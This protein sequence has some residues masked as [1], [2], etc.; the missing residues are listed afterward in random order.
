MALHYCKR[1]GRVVERNEH[2]RAED[3]NYKCDSCHYNV[4]PVPEKYWLDGLDYL[5]TKEQKALLREELVK[6]SPEYDEAMFK[7]REIN[8]A[9]ENARWAEEERLR[10]MQ[11]GRNMVSCTYCGST[12]ISKIGFLERL[13]SAELWGL[14][15]SKIGKQFHCNN[16]GANF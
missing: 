3:G 16:C 4:Y 2:N 13:G 12:N 15:S 14:G 10:T 7:R 5:I 8:L 11:A 9:A 1:C 6:T